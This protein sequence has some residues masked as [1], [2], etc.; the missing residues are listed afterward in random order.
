M[1]MRMCIYVGVI[2]IKFVDWLVVEIIEVRFRL[3]GIWVDGG[4]ILDRD[5]GSR[6]VGE[7]DDK[8]GFG[9]IEFGV[10]IYVGFDWGNSFKR[11]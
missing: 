8:F 2:R 6:G 4:D 1:W 5:E 10:F 11:W 3:S 9:S 7:G